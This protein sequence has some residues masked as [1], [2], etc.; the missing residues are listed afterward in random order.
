MPCRAG[1]S[2]LP[3]ACSP[4]ASHAALSKEPAGLAGSQS[5]PAAGPPRAWPPGPTPGRSPSL[6]AASP[7]LHHGVGA[8]RCSGCPRRV[9]QHQG[10][11]CLPLQHVPSLSCPGTGWGIL[12][13][14]LSPSP[15][16]TPWSRGAGCRGWGCR[17]ARGPHGAGAPTCRVPPAASAPALSPS[18]DLSSVTPTHCSPLRQDGGAG[19]GHSRC[20]GHRKSRSPAGRDGATFPHPLGDGLSRGS[21]AEDPITNPFFCRGYLG[22]PFPFPR[23]MPQPGQ[24]PC[25]AP[26]PCPPDKALC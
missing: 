22:R 26:S 1:P 16:E 15:G 6:P 13:P 20:L 17:T 8:R 11:S 25:A 24:R 9:A 4:G 5:A 2:R 14:A 18:S 23:S 10:A 12:V 21:R 3:A 19:G 7:S